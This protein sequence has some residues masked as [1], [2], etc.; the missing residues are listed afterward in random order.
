MILVLGILIKHLVKKERCLK[1]SIALATVLKTIGLI[2]KLTLVHH[3][4]NLESAIDS[5]GVRHLRVEANLLRAGIDEGLLVR[6]ANKNEPRA[7]SVFARR[8]ILFQK[9]LLAVRALQVSL[10]FER[11]GD[12]AVECLHHR[13]NRPLVASLATF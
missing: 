8:H 2:F 4:G 10:V 13:T 11:A 1:L 5:D 3:F 7:K 6:H 12:G 9:Q